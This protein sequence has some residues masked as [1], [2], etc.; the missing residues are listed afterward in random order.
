[1]TNRTLVA[2]LA[3]S[4]LCFAGTACS[5][6][7]KEEAPPPVS[8]ATTPTAPTTAP[9]PPPA[10]AN[11]SIPDAA[12]IPPPPPT[13]PPPVPSAAPTPAPK[14]AAPARTTRSRTA[15]APRVSSETGEF[16]WRNWG[17]AKYAADEEDAKRPEKLNPALDAF[18]AAGLMPRE[19][20]D[21]FAKAV[22]DHPQGLTNP[23]GQKAYITPGMRLDGMMVGGTR[24][25]LRK[26]VRVS[27]TILAQGQVKAIQAYVWGITY[28]GVS[29]LLYDPFTCG[30][31]ALVVSGSPP[32]PPPPP[33]ARD[34]CYL[35]RVVVMG[36]NNDTENHF[37]FYEMMPTGP[38]AA[39]RILRTDGSVVQDWSRYESCDDLTACGIRLR[40]PQTLNGRRLV[41][42]GAIK[43][44]A[45]CQHGC[46]IEKRLPAEFATSS[47]TILR[48]C[49]IRAGGRA[50]C[51]VMVRH[52]DYHE[53]VARVFYDRAQFAT[54]QWGRWRKLYWLFV[55]DPDRDCVAS[56]QP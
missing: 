16:L 35:E 3:V 55:A 19:V 5:R 50:S 30:N 34:V 9:V 6:K 38:C 1:M 32:P 39:F 33:P 47:Q 18:V 53:T 36:R 56:Y 20:A 2:L 54:V 31:W 29:Y 48:E 46:I 25:H 14:K 27:E 23:P 26:N 42:A 13:P 21:Q 7:P 49:L 4:S 43:V 44:P 8:T 22:R 28:N 11:V 15:P 10:A 41:F 17:A 12:L 37:S 52:D 40:V 24:P 45:A 51:G